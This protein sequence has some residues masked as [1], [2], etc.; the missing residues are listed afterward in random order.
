MKQIR[1]KDLMVSAAV[2]PTVSDTAT[3]F[4][5]ILT[6]EVFCKNGSENGRKKPVVLVENTGGV[7]IG[8]LRVWN[9]LKGIEPKYLEIAEALA[10]PNLAVGPEMIRSE[11]E[12][13]GLW[14]NPMGDICRQVG[15]VDI[16]SIMSVL[17]DD[18][19]ID[20]HAPLE[21]VI[22]QLMVTR[23]EDL[24]VMNDGKVAGLVG[25]SDVFNHVC[26]KVR[27]CRV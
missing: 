2:Y 20:A 5:A 17:A 22:H 11:L 23:Y 1:V 14:Q 24:F 3:L 10:S 7:T 21:Q 9:I 26:E 13:H 8:Y 18:E 27:A 25:L 15:E 19:R 4:E 12:K 6:L 16:G